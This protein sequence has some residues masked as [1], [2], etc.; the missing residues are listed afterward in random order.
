VLLDANGTPLPGG[1]GVQAG[2]LATGNDNTGP[3]VITV[4]FTGASVASAK[5][6]EIKG[7]LV[8]GSAAFTAFSGN[9]Q[10]IVSPVGAAA[11]LKP[12]A[13]VHWVKVA[14]KKHHVIKKH[15]H[16]KH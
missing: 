3:Y 4:S 15:K 9:V 5:A 10:Q 1:T 13:K 6:L 16:H 7:P 12:G 14:V 11:V 2:P 8:G